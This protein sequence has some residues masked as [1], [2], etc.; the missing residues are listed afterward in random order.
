MIEAA[1]EAPAQ[2]DRI[3]LVADG[4]G[5]LKLDVPPF[6]CPSCGHTAPYGNPKGHVIKCGKCEARIAHGVAMP[7]VIVEPAPDRRFVTLSF[8]RW[9]ADQSKWVA[10]YQ[11]VVDKDY[12]QAIWHNVQS[13]CR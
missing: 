10:S 11:V 5:G 9:D 1:T 6:S 7:R 3:P 12:G 4:E 2:A 8:Q 13:I